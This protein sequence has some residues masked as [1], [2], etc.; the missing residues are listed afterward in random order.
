LVT[1][2]LHDEDYAIEMQNDLIPATEKKNIVIS[3]SLDGDIR[4]WN[5]TTCTTYV[6]T[7]LADPVF[8]LKLVPTYQ[9]IDPIELEQQQQ[10]KK[11]SNKSMQLD[12]LV[13]TA[14]QRVD[15]NVST[16]NGKVKIQYEVNAFDL[17][18]LTKNDHLS[19]IVMHHHNMEYISVNAAANNRNAT[20]QMITAVVFVKN[21]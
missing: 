21:K 14:H 15:G 18:T 17:E 2:I 4:I 13:T 1:C 5:L 8:K 20:Q 11:S 19:T 6:Q 16:G 12:L 10:Q 3:A 9:L 7:R